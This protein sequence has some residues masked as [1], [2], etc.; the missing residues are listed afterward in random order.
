M[1]SSWPR[2]RFHS[3]TGNQVK[4]TPVNKYE[5]ILERSRAKYRDILKKMR[6][7]SRLKKPN[8]DSIVHRF[9][10][11]VFD[12]I[13]C[14]ECGLC[15]R[16]MGPVFRNTDIKHICSYIGSNEKEFIARYL[17]QDPD[18]VG[19]M[20]KE[21]PCPFQADD[22]T[23]EIYDCRTLSCVNFP[24]TQSVNMQ[25]KLVGLV[26][27]SRFCPAAFLICEKIIKEYP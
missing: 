4:E 23:C 24:H 21:L 1:W 6:H 5:R 15:C 19:Y 17:V 3:I 22:N 16:N 20:L 13:D 2:F 25:K 9:H 12:E 10:D 7:L 8:F 11:E 27:D 18:G 14:T 26:L